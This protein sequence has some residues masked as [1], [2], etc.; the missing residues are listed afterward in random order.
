MTNYQKEATEQARKARRSPHYWA[1]RISDQFLDKMWDIMDGDGISQAELARRSGVSRQRISKMFNGYGNF[2]I[3]TM[4]TVALA[5]GYKIDRLNITVVSEKI[6]YVPPPISDVWKAATP[7]S[8]VSSNTGSVSFTE[9][10]HSS[11]DDG[12]AEYYD[13]MFS[14]DRAA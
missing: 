14:K 2:T 11:N 7:I 12:Y 4:Q 6:N 10:L 3:E 5:L 13:D 1:T 9:D 8:L